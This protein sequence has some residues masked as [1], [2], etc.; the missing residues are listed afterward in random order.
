MYRISYM[1]QFSDSL[2]CSV[3]NS[4]N[5]KNDSFFNFSSNP[6]I[7][8]IISRLPYS[9]DTLDSYYKHLYSRRPNYVSFLHHERLLWDLKDV[10]GVI[11][12][13]LSL[14]F[15]QRN[16]EGFTALTFNHT[17]LF[18]RIIELRTQKNDLEVSFCGETQEKVSEVSVKSF[19]FYN[20]HYLEKSQKLII[21][22]FMEPQDG[23][24]H[25]NNKKI[26]NQEIFEQIQEYIKSVDTDI[27]SAYLTFNIIKKACLDKN[28]KLLETDGNSKTLVTVLFN[29]FVAISN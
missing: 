16:L 11:I 25:M 14:I 5:S 24:I 4:S 19:L 15:S 6:V 22:L 8:K 23:Y 21:E 18:Y 28:T 12:P 2:S 10:E 3:N 1:E 7:H 27:I 17:P 26:I 29:L 13:M 20:V 9:S